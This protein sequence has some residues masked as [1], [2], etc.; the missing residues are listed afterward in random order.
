MIH[1]PAWPAGARQAL[2]APKDPGDDGEEELLARRAPLR[3]DTWQT[4]VAFRHIHAESAS[5]LPG[6][7]NARKAL[8]APKDPGDDGEEELL[9]RRAPLGAGAPRTIQSNSYNATCER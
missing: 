5:S 2:E 4:E 7:Q 6:L 3:A 9:A 8:K 1:Q